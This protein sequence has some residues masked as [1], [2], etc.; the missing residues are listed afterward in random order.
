MSPDGGVV[1]AP[2]GSD[3]VNVPLGT[4]FTVS[5]ALQNGTMLPPA[6]YMSG[7]GCVLGPFMGVSPSGVVHWC[8]VPSLIH[9][10]TP[11]FVSQVKATGLRG[12]NFE[13]LI[14]MRIHGLTPA[15]I[16]EA[17]K[18]FKDL[19]IDQMIK[20]KQLGILSSSETI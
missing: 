19:S 1:V 9:G 18:H 16:R 14:A 5:P 4:Q 17:Q 15:D 2:A 10:V 20:L 13:R 11:D 3:P 8:G 6:K 7:T 12:L